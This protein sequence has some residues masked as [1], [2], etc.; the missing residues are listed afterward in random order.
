[1]TSVVYEP[2]RVRITVDGHCKED[3]PGGSTVCAAVSALVYTLA[4]HVER[5]GCIGGV[6]LSDS[7]SWSRISGMT[8]S[9][10]V[11]DAIA[12]G[13]ECIAE[14]YPESVEFERV[15]E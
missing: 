7:S 1:M 4:E 15:E 3:F 6:E 11:F 8:E 5:S 14:Q 13:L 9:R 2:E 10:P 12:L